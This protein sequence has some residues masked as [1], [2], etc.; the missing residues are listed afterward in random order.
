MKAL[1][2]TDL[3]NRLKLLESYISNSGDIN[4]TVSKAN[5]AWHIDHS[6][7]VMNAVVKNMQESDPTLY[8]DN[9]SF[10][11]KVLLQ[12]NYFPKGKAKAPKHVL[13]PEI[14]LKEDIVSQLETAKQNLNEIL[15]LDENAFFKH[16][17]FGN[18]NTKRVL[19]FL[20]AHTNHHL[21]IIKNILK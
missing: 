8:V 21:K 2:T 13:P 1:N 11:G 4:T 15:K 5:V 17:L 3:E 10:I 16:P 9:F 18:I 7:K 6:L 20:N 19:R 12:F 14:I